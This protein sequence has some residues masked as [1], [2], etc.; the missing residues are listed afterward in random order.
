LTD[1]VLSVER[2]IVYLTDK[3]VIRCKSKIEKTYISPPFGWRRMA[4]A[5]GY[6]FEFSRE[7][8]SNRFVP[9]NNVF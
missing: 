5:R 3:S 9:G 1:T 7:K 8:F 6:P 4:G 2:V